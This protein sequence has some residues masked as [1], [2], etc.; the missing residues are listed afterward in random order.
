MLTILAL[1]GAAIAATAAQTVA[2]DAAAAAVQAYAERYKPGGSAVDEQVVAEAPA[3][4]SDTKEKAEPTKDDDD[5]WKWAMMRGKLDLKDKTIKYP[6]FV[7]FCVNLYN[8]ADRF[9]N[10]YDSAYVVGTGKRWKVQIKN[11]NWTDSY[12]L[13]FPSS[14]TVRL[15]SQMSSNIGGSVSYMAVSVGYML[16]VDYIFAGSSI[17]H[18][19]WDFQFSCALFAAD[20]YFAKNTG[21][22]LLQRI[23]D[24][25][26][27]SWMNYPF[28]DLRSESYGI[29]LYYFFNHKKYSQ[30]A[31]Y[32]FSKFQKKSSGSVISGLMISSQDVRMDFSNLSNEMIV[33]LPEID[34][35]N[36]HF[37]YYDFCVLAGYGYNC[38]MGRH[39]LFNISSLPS[40]GFKHCLVVS[41]EGES[42]KFSANIKAKMA[43]VY[44]NG[45]F[46]ASFNGKVDL[47]WYSSKRYNFANT[48][49]YFNFCAGW[50]F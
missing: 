47:H 36:Y 35:L 10:T 23:G 32:N 14:T 7:G 17:T 38:V 30:G 20:M 3:A 12:I 45:D 13:H 40:L 37:R 22:T 9:F 24:Y 39:W 41:E 2:C 15:M 33:Q 25:N 43:F 6:K 48:I 50:R 1:V 26:G 42:Y 49:S 44:N 27:S 4:E 28:N 19:K 46:F 16:D 21:S 11:D 8:W 18:K 31:A 29:D 34:N 5:Y